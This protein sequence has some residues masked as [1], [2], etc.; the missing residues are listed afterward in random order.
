ML[1]SSRDTLLL[2]EITALLKEIRD[3]MKKS[4]ERE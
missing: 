3:L 4:M 2:L 1:G